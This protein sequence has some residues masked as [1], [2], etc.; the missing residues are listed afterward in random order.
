MGSPLAPPR[1]VATEPAAPEGLAVAPDDSSLLV[2]EGGAGRLVR[3]ELATGRLSTVA[4]GLALGAQGIPGLVPTWSFNGVAVGP[5]GAVYVSGDKA[6]VL[7]RL[8]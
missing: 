7:Y 4:D 5:S 2:V 6:N 3:I 1:V 8:D